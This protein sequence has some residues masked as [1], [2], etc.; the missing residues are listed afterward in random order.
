MPRNRSKPSLNHKP[1]KCTFS[2]VSENELKKYIC[3]GIRTQAVHWKELKRPSNLSFTEASWKEAE[4]CWLA[5]WTPEDMI[6]PKDISPK[7]RDMFRYVYLCTIF[8]SVKT[9]KKQVG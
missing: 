4:E 7:M 2:A 3:T 9:F 8:T 5:Y 1:K 6:M